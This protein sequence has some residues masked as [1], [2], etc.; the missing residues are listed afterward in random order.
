MII[1]IEA[2]KAFDKIQ[3]PFMIKALKKLGIEGM[4]LNIIKAI[5]H[6]PKAN[7]TLSGEKLKPFLLKSG[8]NQGCPFSPVLFKI[9][10][11]FLAR[12]IRQEEEIKGIQIGKEEV[13]LSLFADI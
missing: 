1:S 10:L 9:V 7:I 3:H 12:A 2:E 13:R 8:M 4:H 11:E 6:D 5:Y